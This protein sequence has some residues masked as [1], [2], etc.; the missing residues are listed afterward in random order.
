[1]TSAFK[2]LLVDDEPNN[3]KLLQQILKDKYKL[4]FASDGEQAI[5]AA[6]LHLPDMILLDVMMPG[7]SGY[8]VCK[9]LKT[10]EATKDIP[11]IFVTAMTDLNDEAQGFDVGA[12]DYIFKPIS[13]QIV[14]RRIE[15]HLSLVRLESLKALIHSAIF[16]LGEAGHYNDTDTGEHIWRM[17]AYSVTIARTKG[18]DERK[19]ELLS[20]AAPMHDTGKIGIPDSILKAE[21]ALTEEEWVIMKTHSKIGS[22]ILRK[23]KNPVFVMAAEIALNHHEKWDGTGYPNGLSGKEIPESAR[24]VAITDIFDALTVKRPYKEPWPAEQAIQYILEQ[25]GKHLDP[26]LVD[27]FEQNIDEL[28]SIKKKW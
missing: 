23:S 25:S 2:I 6:T 17:A 13:A 1:M 28:L 7:I 10:I 9:K 18:W 5:V 14:L 4:I 19:L 3:L 20:L 27:I 22:D 12:V 15:T 11:I 26:E 24:I 8:D 16:M 21:R